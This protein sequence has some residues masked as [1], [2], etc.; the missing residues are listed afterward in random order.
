MSTHTQIAVVGGG[1]VGKAAAVTSARAGFTTR[2][3]APAAP[4]DRRTSALMGPSVDYLMSAQLIDAPDATGVPLSRIRIIDCTDR[5]LRAPETVFDAR[6]TGLEAFGYNFPNAKLAESFERAAEGI[7]TLSHKA[8]SVIS[9]VRSDALWH[10]TLD[11]GDVVT[12]DLLVGADGKGSSIRAA[13]G[14]AVREKKYAQAALVCDLELD[15]PLDGESVE[16]HF[17]N[18]PFTLVPAGG[19]RANL[20]WIDRRETLEAARS[21][22]DQFA[23]SLA[24]KSGRAFGRPVPVT[25][26]FVFALSSLSVD[27]AGKDGAVLVGES[28]H[29]FPPIG[30]QG[31][32]LGL[33]DLANL[34]KCLGVANPGSYGWAPALSD[35]YARGRRGDLSRTGAF[36]DGLFGSLLSKHIPAQALRTAGLWG[37]KTLPG[38]RRRAIAFGLGQ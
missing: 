6:E 22:P 15:R 26:S 5:L 37:L 11:G 8:A 17:P 3:I 35:A 27:T 30:A 20:V 24:Q 21:D 19:K 2:H 28:A 1:L 36:V 29:A 13:A 31:L 32:N 33:R 16:F 9:A 38:L 14:I 7:E 25:P 12:C 18:G 23:Q 34:D 10:L 4:P